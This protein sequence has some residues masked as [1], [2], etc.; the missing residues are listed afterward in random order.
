MLDKFEDNKYDLIY[1]SN[2]VHIW[3]KDLVIM[4]KQFYRVLKENG[5]YIFFET[6]PIIRPF[7]DSGNE[8]KIVKPYDLIGPF[9]HDNCGDEYKWRVE[10]FLKGLLSAEFTIKDYREIKS[11]PIDLMAHNWFYNS[12]EELE[13]DNAKKF[14]WTKNPWAALPQWMS[15]K[16]KKERNI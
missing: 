3:I 7:N 16:V 5:Y 2:G 8:I 12:R 4:Y 1:T 11:K 13:K 6:H 14:D 9:H 10:D 15:C